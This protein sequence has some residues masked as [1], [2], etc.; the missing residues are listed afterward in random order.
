MVE[1]I[2]LFAACAVA[3]FALV[4]RFGYPRRL[5][6]Q[7]LRLM[8]AAA[9]LLGAAAGVI[10]GSARMASPPTCAFIYLIFIWFLCRGGDP[11][12]LAHRLLRLRPEQRTVS[13][14]KK[15]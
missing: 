15:P 5:D 14:T 7:T 2:L 10:A 3:L 11:V 4:R 8:L 13:L 1:G 6:D 12:G 9:C